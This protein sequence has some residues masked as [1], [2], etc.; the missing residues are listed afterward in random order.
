MCEHTEE[1]KMAFLRRAH[2]AGVVNI[3]MECSAMAA[4]CRKV[5]RE[6][7]EGGRRE[8]H[9]KGRERREGVGNGRKG[10]GG[11]RGHERKGE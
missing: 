9:E 7:R 4:L 10:E 1:Q 3:E 5:R 6:R 8:G 2:S 11:G